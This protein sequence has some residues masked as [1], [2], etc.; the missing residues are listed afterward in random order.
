MKKKICI[1]MMMAAGLTGVMTGCVSTADQQSQF[2]VPFLKDDAKGEYKNRSVAQALD[3]CRTVMN[4]EGQL[5]ADNTINHSL[6]GKVKGVNIYIRVDEVDVT[7]PQTKVLVQARTAGGA[8]DADL[9]QDLLTK[10]VLQM[11]AQAQ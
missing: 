11:T 8:A 3:A 1:L 6:R 10:I 4:T 5:T 2:G 7:T 9:A